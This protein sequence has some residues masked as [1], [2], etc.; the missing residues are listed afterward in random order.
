M[1]HFIQPLV[2]G[3]HP[4]AAFEALCRCSSCQ[5]SGT[6]WLR[7]GRYLALRKLLPLLPSEKCGACKCRDSWPGAWQLHCSPGPEASCN[8]QPTSAFLSC[9]PQQSWSQYLLPSRDSFIFVG[10]VLYLGVCR[11]AGSLGLLAAE[12]FAQCPVHGEHADRNS[13]T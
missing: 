7:S 8:R 3:A 13:S 5:A 1:Q 10:W 2:Y 4:P 11:V 6:L 9:P 12:S